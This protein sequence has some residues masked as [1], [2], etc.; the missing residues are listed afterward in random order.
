MLL[1]SSEEHLLGRGATTPPVFF[2]RAR[3]YMTLLNTS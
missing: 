2:T 1:L 3:L